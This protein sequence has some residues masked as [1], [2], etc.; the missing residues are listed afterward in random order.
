MARPA[1][2]LAAALLLVASAALAAA[3]AVPSPA[4]C[5]SRVDAIGENNLLLQ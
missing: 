2:A 4:D 1:S 3:Q 5:Q